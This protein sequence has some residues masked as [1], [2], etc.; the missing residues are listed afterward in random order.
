MKAFIINVF[1]VF[2]YT[3]IAAQSLAKHLPTLVDL[4]VSSIVDMFK[5]EPGTKVSTTTKRTA[6]K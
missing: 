1:S 4:A 5:P 3:A 2:S 6:S